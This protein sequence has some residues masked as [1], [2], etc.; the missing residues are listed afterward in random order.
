MAAPGNFTPSKPTLVSAPLP[1]LGSLVLKHARLGCKV[2]TRR[3]S[4][5]KSRL[6][7]RPSP[8]TTRHSCLAAG[9]TWLYKAYYTVGSTGESMPTPGRV[10][11]PG[12][13]DGERPLV[14]RVVADY[15][16]LSSKTPAGHWWREMLPPARLTS[17]QSSLLAVPFPSLEAYIWTFGGSVAGE[18]WAIYHELIAASTRQQLPPI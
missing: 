6:D 12:S 18:S 15:P 13:I 9:W 4:P 3:G 14:L 5:D 1:D 11:P 7:S 16:G 8:E 17:M 2:A 10:R